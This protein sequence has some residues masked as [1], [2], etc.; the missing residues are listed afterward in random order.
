MKY[1][2]GKILVVQSHTLRV[3]SNGCGK[4]SLLLLASSSGSSSR[5]LQLRIRHCGT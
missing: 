5:C 2:L 1:E 3:V 4:M